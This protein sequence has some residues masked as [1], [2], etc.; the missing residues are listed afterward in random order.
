MAVIDNISSALSSFKVNGSN[1]S[2]VKVTGTYGTHDILNG[3][4]VVE[5]ELEY[6]FNINGLNGHNIK[7]III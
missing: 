7:N 2:L 6:T 1:K 4:E 5:N 3:G